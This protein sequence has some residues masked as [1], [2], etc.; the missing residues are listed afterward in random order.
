M[1][2]KFIFYTVYQKCDLNVNIYIFLIKKPTIVI[3]WL[4][5]YF[6]YIGLVRI[7]NEKSNTGPTGTT[8]VGLIVVWLP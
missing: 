5:Y 4:L 6:N 2:P 3:R 8:P 1:P 7:Y